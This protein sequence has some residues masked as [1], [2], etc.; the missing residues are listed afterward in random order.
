M[1]SDAVISEAQLT[2]TI[3]EM[4]RAHNRKDDA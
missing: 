1:T 3:I 2:Q 4:A